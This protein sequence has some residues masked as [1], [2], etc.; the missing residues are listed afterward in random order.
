MTRATPSEPL[1]TS[2]EL[3]AELNISYQTCCSW[4]KAAKL[5][6]LRLPDGSYRYRRADI[7]AWL[8]ARSNR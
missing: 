4:S 7:D 1:L 6:C 8:A 3:C 2:R 5:P